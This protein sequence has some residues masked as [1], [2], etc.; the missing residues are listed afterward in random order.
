MRTASKP[1]TFVNLNKAGRELIRKALTCNIKSNSVD[2]FGI[3]LC[4][5]RL[6]HSNDNNIHIPI[7]RNLFL[8]AINAS[9]DAAAWRSLPIS[10]LRPIFPFHRS[11]NPG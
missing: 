7:T 1:V 6:L 2:Y 9:S 5:C 10:I 3:G 8:H 11:G 4:G